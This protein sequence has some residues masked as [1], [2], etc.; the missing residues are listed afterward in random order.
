MNVDL[1]SQMHTL[2]ETFSS[3][4]IRDLV[5]AGAFALEG[6]LKQPGP[7]PDNQPF[8]A[9]MALDNPG[10]V[11]RGISSFIRYPDE[12]AAKSEARRSAS[13]YGGRWAVLRAMHTIG[14][15]EVQMNAADLQLPF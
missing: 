6:K 9:V 3:K 2:A 1:A 5:R 4:E 14:W 11:E 12:A 13:K 15:Q 10:P 7:Q 8:W